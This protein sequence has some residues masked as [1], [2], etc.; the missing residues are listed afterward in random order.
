M[1]L[2]SLTQGRVLGVVRQGSYSLI[3]SKIPERVVTFHVVAVANVDPK[4]RTSQRQTEDI[5]L[6]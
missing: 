5:F 1:S 6:V 4:K 3:D 2:D